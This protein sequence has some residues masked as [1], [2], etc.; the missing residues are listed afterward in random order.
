VAVAARAHP[1]EGQF[2]V[3]ERSRSAG[4]QQCIHL[5][6]GE[7]RV[8]IPLVGQLSTIP[9]LLHPACVEQGE[10]FA[11]EAALLLQR[12]VQGRKV[13]R[14]CIPPAPR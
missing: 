11:A 10:L 12:S 13:I 5:A 8:P 3:G 9:G 7:N 4:R 2:D 1:G 14:Q 6:E